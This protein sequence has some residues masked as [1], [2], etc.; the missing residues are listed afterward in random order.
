[1]PVDFRFLFLNFEFL[2]WS[3]QF[4]FVDLN[5]IW[6]SSNSNE[7][8]P[9]GAKVLMPS[10]QADWKTKQLFMKDKPSPSSEEEDEE[11]ARLAAEE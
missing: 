11:E 8:Q 9:Q 10:Y 4:I 7:S 5:S 6:L 1:M 3:N 2:G